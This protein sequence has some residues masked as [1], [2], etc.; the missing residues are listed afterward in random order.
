MDVWL[1]TTSKESQI[2]KNLREAW[3]GDNQRGPKPSAQNEG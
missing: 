3:S 1:D 2:W